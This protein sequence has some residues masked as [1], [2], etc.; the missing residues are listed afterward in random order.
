MTWAPHV[1]VATVVCRN[2]RFLMVY[3]DT[4][5]GPAYNQPAGHLEPN[6]TLDA[7]AERETLEETGWVVRPT[8]VLAVSLLKAANGITYVRTTFIAEAIEEVKH[9]LLDTGIIRA[10]W[11][12]YDEI[13]AHKRILRS[14]LVLAD[15]ELY[16]SGIRYPLELVRSLT[17]E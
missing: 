9:A 8:G 3:E 1:T 11:L 17:V 2:N 5:S 6:E 14:P 15:V 7:A 13:V 10:A 16:R 12:S 4:E